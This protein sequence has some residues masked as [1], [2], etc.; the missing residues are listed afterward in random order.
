MKI[1]LFVPEANG[2]DRLPKR[3]SWKLSKAR[4]GD[5]ERANKPK[6]MSSHVVTVCELKLAKNVSLS[7]TSRK[8]FTFFPPSTQLSM[9]LDCVLVY[10]YF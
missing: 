7:L 10:R 3:T 6:R 2:R 9:S 8:V 1:S 5:T 4:Q